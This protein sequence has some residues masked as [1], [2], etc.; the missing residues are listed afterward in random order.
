MNWARSQKIAVGPGRGSAAGSIVAYLTGITDIDPIYH[1]L[2][3]ERFLN[4][5]RLSMPDIDSDLE[6]SRR[7]EVIQYVRQR[8]GADKV[9][10]IITF[11]TMLARNAI[12]D[13]GRAL[14]V[15]Y[16]ECDYIAKLIPSGPGGMTLKEAL[17]KIPELKALYDSNEQLAH[18]MNIAQ[19]LEG[20]SRHT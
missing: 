1:N 13:V 11:G 10:Q 7:E 16:A 2:I 20:V 15:S 9:A 12:R 19:T 5:E 3:F 18:M 4:P 14:G 17:E 8:Y 6:D